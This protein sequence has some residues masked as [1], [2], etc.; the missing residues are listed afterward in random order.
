[1]AARNKRVRTENQERLVAYLLAHPCI[2]CGERDPVVLDF[3]HIVGKKVKEVTAL[4]RYQQWASIEAEI[5]KCV[6]RC[7]NCH[8]R[9]T[10]IERNSYR[11]RVKQTGNAVRS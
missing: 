7:A 10:A 2:D 11:M 9:K 6:V 5:A 3:D 1:M 4:A 8:R